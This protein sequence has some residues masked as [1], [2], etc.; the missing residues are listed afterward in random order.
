ME[1]ISAPFS[2]KQVEAL[3][4]F[5]K[6]GKDYPFT[7][8]G[9]PHIPNKHSAYMGRTRAICPNEGLLIA[10]EKGFICPCGSYTED[11]AFKFMTE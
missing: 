4:K 9:M 3:N 7:C 8:L 1:R 11:W 2:K 5:Q 6:S 10:T